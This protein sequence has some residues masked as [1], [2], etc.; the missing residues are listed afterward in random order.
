MGHTD[1]THLPVAVDATCSGLQILAGLAKDASTARM[2]NVIGSEKPQDA[3]ATIASKS[4]DAIPDRL[5]PHWD[6]K[7]TKRCVMTIPYNAKPFSNRSYIRDAFKDKGCRRRQRRVDTMRKSC[8]ICHERGS[9]GS[10][11]RNEMD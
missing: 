11:E 6:R 3:Y 8:T 10:Y 4:M 2:V 1:T 9:S 5:K 7:V